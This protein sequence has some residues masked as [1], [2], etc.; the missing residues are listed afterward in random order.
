MSVKAVR[1]FSL[2]KL[3][4]MFN[5]AKSQMTLETIVARF[6]T[7]FN[8]ASFVDEMKNILKNDDE[9]GEKSVKESSSDKFSNAKEVPL[10]TITASVFFPRDS[11][12]Y[13]I[14]KGME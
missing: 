7:D 9:K 1:E 3:A 14:V 6:Q 8:I 4:D 11:D 13:E 5:K 10:A 2:T 12:I